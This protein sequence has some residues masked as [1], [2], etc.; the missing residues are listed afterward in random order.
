[1]NGILSRL[2]PGAG[3]SVDYAT[4]WGAAAAFG[5]VLLA[6]LLGGGLG[7]FI[8][9][10]SLLI[11]VGGTLGATLITFPLYDLARTLTII[12]PALFPDESSAQHRIDKI[13]DLSNKTRAEGE[14]SLEALT[15]SELD[16]FL[17]KC[18]ELVV[19]GTPPEEIHRILQIEVSHL[20]DRHR[21]GAQLL[22]T[23]GSISPAMGLI[24]TLIG[25]VRMLENLDDPANIGPGMALA[26]LTTFYGA[27]LAHLVFL[28]LAGKLRTR[29]EEERLIKE[30]TAEG[31][32]SV[33][34]GVNPRI[35]EQRLQSFLP[36][37]QR[38]S[39]FS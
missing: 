15:Y 12:R 19:D 33:A 27:M 34:Q 36:N 2:R 10:K 9:I 18:I 24:G 26:L 35:I 29:S 39:R 23:M 31:I 8:D 1:M 22:Q 7:S 28:P 5:L 21:R 4:L 17:R 14:L 37:E 3:D 11:V 38:Y 6:I 32:L 30:L 13:I 25:L 20:E 16:S